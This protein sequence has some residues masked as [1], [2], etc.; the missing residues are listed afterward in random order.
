[1]L[2]AIPRALCRFQGM[3]SDKE[4]TAIRV[5][6]F[7]PTYES[8]AEPTSDFRKRGVREQSGKFHTEGGYYP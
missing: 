1:M 2:C 8:S 4:W 7:Y 3:D 6:H 5:S